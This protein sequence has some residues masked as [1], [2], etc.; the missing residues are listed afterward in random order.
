MSEQLI[1]YEQFE[2]SK[3]IPFQILNIIRSRESESGNAA[4][5]HHWHSELEICYIQEGNHTKHVVDGKVI[6]DTEG[7]VIVVN[8]D[9]IHNIIDVYDDVELGHISATVIIISKEF[10]N[11]V[12]PNY[13]QI[14]FAPENDSDNASLGEIM[15]EL[16]KYGNQID[17]TPNIG[18]LDLIHIKALMYELV[19]R[20]MSTRLS[21][22]NLELPVNKA[23]NLERIKGVVSYIEK[24]YKEPIFQSAV[25]QKFYFSDSYFSRYFHK[26]MNMTFVDYLSKYRNMQARTLLIATDKSVTEIAMECGFSDSRRFILSF[27]KQ[28]GVTPLQ[29]RK[30][31]LMSKNGNF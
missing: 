22:R 2:Y 29:Y 25:A 8:S 11:E 16:S 13:D 9:S 1:R 21:W 12:I 27:K 19:Y 31:E 7:K 5:Q 23:K 26:T 14:Y 6:S 24:H 10:L 4:L 20:L 17:G 15:R 28:Y 3:D 30:V 18:E